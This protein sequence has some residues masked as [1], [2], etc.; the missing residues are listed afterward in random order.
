[1]QHI[2]FEWS[3]SHRTAWPWRSSRPPEPLAVLSPL[4][5]PP[6]SAP[7]LRAAPISRYWGAPSVWERREGLRGTAFGD[8]SVWERLTAGC[9]P[10]SVCP[11]QRR[12]HNGG[13]DLLGPGKNR[14]HAATAPSAGDLLSP[15]TGMPAG[16]P[17]AMPTHACRT[18][19]EG[20][21]ARGAGR[22]GKEGERGRKEREGGRAGPEGEE[23]EAT[24]GRGRGEEG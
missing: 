12:P 22:R 24:W 10:E 8:T 19:G 6:Q 11:S 17:P 23:T 1:M 9:R 2:N 3:P 4:P 18:E 15:E 20:R 16:E 21:R 5:S 13:S 14:R 7:P